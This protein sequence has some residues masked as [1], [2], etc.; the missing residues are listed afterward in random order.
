MARV[1]RAALRLP[2][3]AWWK[4]SVVLPSSKRRAAAAAVE[5]VP[6]SLSRTDGEQARL[7][8]MLRELLT[9]QNK[10]LSELH[11]HRQE[12]DLLRHQLANGVM[13]SM[14]PFEA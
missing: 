3:P 2:E 12:T 10:L 13:V 14:Q 5:C 1:E 8:G 9:T 7:E 6:Q 4:L 11:F